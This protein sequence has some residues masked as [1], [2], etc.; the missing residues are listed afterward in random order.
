MSSGFSVELCL[1]EGKIA[2]VLLD[3]EREIRSAAFYA[4]QASAQLG[5]LYVVKILKSVSGL[6]GAFVSLGEVGEGFLPYRKHLS[7][8]EGDFLAA[9]V[10][11][12]AQHGKGIRLKA[13]PEIEIPQTLQLE[14]KPVLIRKA[15]SLLENWADLYP[16][17]QFV[18]PQPE[19][20]LLLPQALRERFRIDYEAFDSCL[21]E[22]FLA[23]GERH[24]SLTLKIDASIT[25]TEALT[26]IDL[27]APNGAG[28]EE[29]R[30]AI[31]KLFDEIELRQLGGVI[32]IDPAGLP[33]KKRFAL[34]KFIQEDAKQK[35]KWKNLEVRGA[36]PSGMIELSVKRGRRSLFETLQELSLTN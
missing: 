13:E 28:F 4:P 18:S 11:R 36:T 34:T 2:S 32:L 15:K 3:D 5:D 14:K 8:Q 19:I 20:L 30:Q 33:V 29:N 35:A 26:A 7:F 22:D 12:E 17:I 10:T 6:S 23:L 31:H 1:I 25:V 21:K 9:S 27:D 16:D 24:F